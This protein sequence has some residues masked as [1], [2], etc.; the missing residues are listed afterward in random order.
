MTEVERVGLE[1]W[2]AIPATP[3]Y[4][5]STHGRVRSYWKRG[6][7]LDMSAKPKI[8][9]ISESSSR[10]PTVLLKTEQGFFSEGLAGII[11]LTFRGN[12]PKKGLVPSHL[13]GNP[14]NNRLDNLAYETV[15]ER[16]ARIR[17]VSPQKRWDPTE[18][19]QWEQDICTA[20]LRGDRVI[21]IANKFQTP[22]VYKILDKHNIPRRFPTGD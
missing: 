17:A 2:R 11:L 1:I 16:L 4:E 3:G 14:R 20:Y 12:P 13:D 9:S 22:T 6:K 15:T 10:S 18:R 5:A 8:K 19:Q 21:D 7:E